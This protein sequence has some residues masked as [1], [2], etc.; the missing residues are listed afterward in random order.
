[1]GDQITTSGLLQVSLPLILYTLP[2][3]LY[4]SLVSNAIKFLQTSH[5]LQLVIEISI[6]LALEEN[7]AGDRISLRFFLLYTKDS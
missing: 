2:V 5:F 3:T 4:L 7:K 1:M 6:C